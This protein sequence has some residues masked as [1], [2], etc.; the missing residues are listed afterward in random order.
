MAASL[1]PCTW[2]SVM[3]NRAYT[4]H[5]KEAPEPMA[6]RVSIL[7]ALCFMARKPD[8]KKRWLISMTM[9]ARSICTRPMAT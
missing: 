9:M 6:T 1:P 8:T 7:G 3:A 5:R 2:A 4:L